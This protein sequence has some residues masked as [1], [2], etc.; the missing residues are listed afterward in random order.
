MPRSEL[1]LTAQSPITH[2]DK[3]LGT[4]TYLRRERY[5]SPTGEVVDVPTISGNALRGALRDAAAVKFHDFLGIDLPLPVSYAL[6]SGGKISKATTIPLSGEKLRLVREAA[7]PLSLL[8]WA[9]AGRI[10]SGS[11]SVGN[12]IPVC[13]ELAHLLPE[14]IAHDALPSYWDITQLDE[15]SHFPDH[16]EEESSLMR[17]GYES[18]I[19]GT[20]FYS[21]IS[22]NPR[23]QIEEGFLA[24]LLGDF[25]TGEVLLGGNKARGNGMFTGAYLKKNVSSSEW[26]DELLLLHSREETAAL[27]KE[28]IK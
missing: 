8:G 9:S 27:L 13:N 7:P 4:I 6:W 20:K 25:L 21:W 3:T 19:P 1:L 12:V 5:L 10:I 18:F 24:E 17:Y 16:E 26:R 14:V 22:C 28:H 15:F 2:G 11:L 23:T